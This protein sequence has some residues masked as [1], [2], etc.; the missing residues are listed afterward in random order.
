VHVVDQ[1]LAY[2]EELHSAGILHRDLKPENVFLLEGKGDRAK[3]IDFGLAKVAEDPNAAER[4]TRQ[5]AVFGTP[6][7]MSPEQG[8]GETV[9][10]R[11]DLYACGIILYELLC[12][13]P[14]FGGGSTVQ[15][16]RRHMTA[17]VPHPR[18]KYAAADVPEALWA[19]LQHVLAKQREERPADARALRALLHPFLSVAPAA[20]APVPPQAA[21]RAARTTPAPI[22]SPDLLVAPDAA[23]G[24]LGDVERLLT[25][26]VGP[27]GR[28]LVGEALQEMA[29]TPENLPRG[30]VGELITR[31]VEEIPAGAPRAEAKAALER[32][33]QGL[34]P[35]P[36]AFDAAGA[37]AAGGRASGGPISEALITGAALARLLGA[38]ETLLRD[39]VGPMAAIVLDD[40]LEEVG[41][42]RDALARPRLVDLV[43]LVAE[44]VPPARRSAFQSRA[45]ELA[46][47][48]G[49]EP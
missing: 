13:Q 47:A 10:A 22:S 3:V 16:L 15:I 8:A 36:G 45:T 48:V 6:F 28:V 39:A 17:P 43:R 12:G 11:T 7:Y 31:L 41:A 32:R 21:P 18:E 9:D 4:L 30:A 20:A 37:A 23:A 14:P 40:A 26:R 49:K 42:G 19:V 24:F 25:E 34:P 1:V 35:V 38:L 44:N 33:A 46:S 29:L 2:L 27:M 5:G